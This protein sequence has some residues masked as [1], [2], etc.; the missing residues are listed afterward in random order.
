M[1]SSPQ[2]SPPLEGLTCHCAP[3]V[4]TS[5]RC[6][7]HNTWALSAW[8]GAFTAGRVQLI[9][10]TWTQYNVVSLSI[11]LSINM[12][13]LNYYNFIKFVSIST[14]RSLFIF[15]VP[16]LWGVIG[17]LNNQ[18]NKE[19]SHISLRALWQAFMYQKDL[20]E[21]RQEPS[22]DKVIN[23]FLFTGKLMITRK[24]VSQIM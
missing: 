1:V 3:K 23:S 7:R 14:H 11:L 6:D 12:K 19:V 18:L 8:D 10:T 15:P 4:Y 21:K 9:T 13:G 24:R 5:V 17:Q 22:E 16:L 2:W 20:E